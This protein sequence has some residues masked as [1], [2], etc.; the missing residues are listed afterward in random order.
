M[1]AHLPESDWKKFRRLREVAL[2]R[3]CDRTLQEIVRL[4]AD[5]S[6]GAHQRYLAIY[7]L[8]QR[9]DREMARAFD[10]PRRSRVLQQLSAMH[11]L[12]LLEVGELD[13]FTDETREA[14]E[15]LST[16]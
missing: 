7:E 4:A 9:R 14:V 8:I 3:L 6:S 2:E 1:A 15:L 12:G 11:A 10:D 13:A 16:L 5:A